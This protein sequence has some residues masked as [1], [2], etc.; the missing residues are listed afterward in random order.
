VIHFLALRLRRMN[1]GISFLLSRLK[2][3]NYLYIK[4]NLPRIDLMLHLKTNN[5]LTDIIVI[6]RF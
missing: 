3:M 4:L 1:F 5:K 2:K 6:D